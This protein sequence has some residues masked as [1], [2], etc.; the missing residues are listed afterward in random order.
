MQRGPPI[1]DL[2]RNGQDGL[3]EPQQ[4]AL[5]APR[6]SARPFLERLIARPTV[7][8]PYRVEEEPRGL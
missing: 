2:P 4:T 1:D 5:L 3:Y 8:P 7:T 6:A